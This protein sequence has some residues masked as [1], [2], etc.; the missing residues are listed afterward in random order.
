MMS[1]SAEAFWDRHAPKYLAKPI[2]DLPSYEAKLKHVRSLLQPTDTVLE[3]GC[4]SGNT[5]LQLAPY[6]ARMTA[7]DISSQMIKCARGQKQST[8]IKNVRFVHANASRAFPDAP[9]DKILAFS[10]LHLVPDIQATLGAIHNQLKPGGLF[11]SKTV[12]LGERNLGIRSM[13][14]F[15]RTLPFTPDV[16]LISQSALKTQ[17]LQSGFEIIEIK[18]F[19]DQCIDPYIVARRHG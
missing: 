7:S 13:V 12:C 11:I 5:A 18:Y 8:D 2:A 4:G 16:R 10:L 6:C 19:G 14:R 1:T 9:F 15:L 17:I 3:I